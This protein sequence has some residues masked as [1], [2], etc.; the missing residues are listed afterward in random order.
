M[1]FWENPINELLFLAIK[2][3]QALQNTVCEGQLQHFKCKK[4]RSELP[5]SVHSVWLI[6]EHIMLLKLTK[7]MTVW[8]LLR[9]MFSH[10]Y[11]TKAGWP[12][13][14][15]TQMLMLQSYSV[16]HRP[17]NLLRVWRLRQINENMTETAWAKTAEKQPHAITISMKFHAHHRPQWW[18]VCGWVLPGSEQDGCSG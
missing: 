13:L 5:N 10:V 12:D 16:S 3:L 15:R 18:S 11:N 7:E 6:T 2:W 14:K 9:R 4:C 1:D 17:H 8:P